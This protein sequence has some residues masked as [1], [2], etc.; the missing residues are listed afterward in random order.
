MKN[1]PNAKQAQAYWLSATGMTAREISEIMGGTPQT[2][3]SLVAAAKAKAQKA[4]LAYL[5]AAPVYERK[6]GSGMLLAMEAVK[7][8]NL[9]PKTGGFEALKQLALEAKEEGAF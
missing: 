2:A 9:Q 1:I 7:A 6:V 5:Y 3:A 4:G 8:A